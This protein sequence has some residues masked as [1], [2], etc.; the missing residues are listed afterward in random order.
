MRPP[1]LHPS[2][3]IG[4]WV[5]AFQIFSN[6]DRPPLWIFKILIFDH[7]T[8]IVVRIC[9]CIPNFIKIGSRFRP[10]DA[11]NCRM[12]DAVAMATTSWRT[13]QEHDGMWPPKLRQSRSIGRHLKYFPTWRPSA[14]FNFK[15]FNIW[16]HDHHCGPN[17]CCIPN[18]IKIGSH[19]QP[20]DAHNC[21]MF[22]A[23][24]NITGT[25]FHRESTVW[26]SVPLDTLE[27]ISETIL[28]V[29]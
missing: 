8:V 27:V 2:R 1:K 7:V 17:F 16:S 13:C 28:W 22:N 29:V 20:P 12:S 3:S 21:R 5:T 19:I 14:I 4:R 10:P 9:C 11:H 25:V 15:K 24:I 26:F 6:N 23:T 18:F